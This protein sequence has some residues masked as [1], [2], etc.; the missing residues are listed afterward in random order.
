MTQLHR[1]RGPLALFGL[2]LAAVLTLSACSGD[3]SGSAATGGAGTSADAQQTSAQ[4]AKLTVQPA[5]GAKDVAPS[6]AAQVT[7]ANGELQTV[8]LTNPDGKQV[9]GQLAADKRSW[10]ATEDLGYG[11]KYTWSGTALGADGKQITIAGSFTTVSPRKQLTASLNVG[12]NQTYGIAMP[13]ALTFSSKVTD[14]AA[15]ERALTVETAPHT[16]GSW[17]WVSDTSVHWRP[18]EYWQPNTQVK[19][20][21]NLYGLKIGDGTYGK[22]DVTASFSIGR[23]QIVKGD[24]KSHHMQVIRDGVQIADY[25][26]SYGLDSDPGRVTHSGIHV[27]MS[28]HPTYS[29][30]NPRYDY[31]DVNV[32]WAVRISNNG[33]F[34]HGLASSVWAQGKQNVS[35][36]CVNLSPARAKEYYDGA[37]IGDPV[38]IT[39]STQTLSAKDGD[40]SD[41]TYSWADWT[42]LSA[43]AS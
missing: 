42:K 5:D 10:A 2:G 3:G 40:Y 27:V 6:D 19:V 34:I 11:K 24:V 28:K 7:V 13:I 16:E 9:A 33:E 23:S 37:L 30:S 17:A 41:W 15:V 12:D 26:A 18:K 38:E 25:P 29:M 36:G 22:Q 43:L 8:T 31:F 39:G 35:H 32:P 21:A 14:K 20:A 4:P 1:R